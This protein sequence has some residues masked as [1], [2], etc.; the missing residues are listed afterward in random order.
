MTRVGNDL[1]SYQGSTPTDIVNEN[2]NPVADSMNIVDVK[3]KK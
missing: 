3:S 2:S 1:L